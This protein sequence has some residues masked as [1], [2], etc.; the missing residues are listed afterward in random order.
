M[1]LICKKQNKDF[2]STQT[3]QSLSLI[4]LCFINVVFMQSH[5]QVSAKRLHA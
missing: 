5:S 2:I 3:G 1:K 4:R